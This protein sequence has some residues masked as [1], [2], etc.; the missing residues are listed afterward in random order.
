MSRRGVRVIFTADLGLTKQRKAEGAVKT[1]REATFRTQ[2]EAQGGHWHASKQQARENGAMRSGPKARRNAKRGGI[3]REL[4][5]E[6]FRI[7]RDNTDKQP[8]LG[9]PVSRGTGGEYRRKNCWPMLAACQIWP[10]KRILGA[11]VRRDART[12][13][14][15][16][17]T[18]G[19]QGQPG[20]LGR[21]GGREAGGPD[22]TREQRPGRP[23]RPSPAALPPGDVAV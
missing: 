9:H 16:F 1:A 17:A 10:P 12:G 23:T 14:G 13:C 11:T 4:H 15:R 8:F 21:A 2:F 20:R 19:G 18:Q 5:L 7:T 22:Y 3:S 6:A